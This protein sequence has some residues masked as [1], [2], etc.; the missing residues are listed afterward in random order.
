MNLQDGKILNFINGQFFEPQS[1][2]FIETINP[3][4]GEVLAQVP[5]SDEADLDIAISTAKDAFPEWRDMGAEHRLEILYNLADLMDKNL[6]AFIEAEVNDNGMTRSFARNVE[7]PRGAAN[8]RAFADSALKYCG[9][10]F[11][12]NDMA[13]GYIRREPVGIVG[14]ISPWNLPLLLFTWKIAPALAAGNCVIAKPSEVTPLTAYLLSTLINDAGFPKGVLNILHGTGP[15][16]GAAITAHPD[17]A[18][19]SFTGSTATG[20]M[21]GMKA[22]ENFKKPPMLEMGGKNPSLVFDDADFEKAV[23]GVCRAAFSN[24]GQIC[25]CGSR[26]YVQKEL[27]D[28]FK[29]A[30][31][32]RIESIKIGDPLDETTEHGATVSREH[33]EKVLGCIELAKAEGGTILCG[34]GRVSVEGRCKDGYFIAPTLIE[35]VANNSRTNQEEIFGPVATIQPFDSEEDAIRLAN[36]SSYGLAAT[37]WTE[38]LDKAIRVANKLETGMPWI[39]CW[40]LRVLET[41]FGG[42]KNSGNAHREGAPD[43]LEFFTEKKTI[44]S[45]KRSAA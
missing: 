17:I 40:N 39:N 3:A 24:Q 33:M 43:A 27:Y 20:K 13:E 8:F 45:P 1:G 2:N 32:E 44:T 29:M 35:G 5:D 7:V 34:G 37:I 16:I 9:D 6:E 31:I 23:D 36:E 22:A 19:L 4:T 10:E 41:P 12:G 38:D 21:I 18:R 15:K 26:I 14:T 25:L 42:Y 11:F 30:L 28:D